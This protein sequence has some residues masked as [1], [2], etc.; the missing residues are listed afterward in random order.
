[1]CVKSRDCYEKG[2]N[3]KLMRRLVSDTKYRAHLP[4]EAQ[5]K[6]AERTVEATVQQLTRLQGCQLWSHRQDLEE[7]ELSKEQAR[8]TEY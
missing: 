5:N 4:P 3:N 1:M 2:P 6:A 8:L 7:L